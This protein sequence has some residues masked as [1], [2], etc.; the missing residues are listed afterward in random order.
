MFQSI[1][2]PKRAELS[3]CQH[4]CYI[5]IYHCNIILSNA[6]LISH[7]SHNNKTYHTVIIAESVKILSLQLKMEV[8]L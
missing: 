6:T 3:E 2:N 5:N 7:K 4:Y 1:S 8:V